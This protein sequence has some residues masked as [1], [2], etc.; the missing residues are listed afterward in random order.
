MTDEKPEYD[1]GYGRPPKHGRFAPG[2]SG[3]PK[4][5]KKGSK[6]LATD[7]AEELAEKIRVREGVR[8]RSVSKQRAILKALVAK[9]L[10]GDTRAAHLLI[11]LVAAQVATAPAVHGTKPPCPRATSSSSRT[12][13]VATPPRRRRRADRT[14]ARPTIRR[15]AMT[16]LYPGPPR[17]DLGGVSPT[18]L[19]KAMLP[20]D[21]P[22]F[23]AKAFDELMHE[24][25]ERSEY[26]ELLSRKLE[27]VISGEVRRLIVCL[28]PRV[29]KSHVARS[30][31]PPSCSART[32][33]RDPADLT[34]RGSGRGFCLQVYAA[35]GDRL[36]PGG[37]PRHRAGR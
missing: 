7:L 28:P 5:R 30:A 16:D 35:D 21:F 10:K 13:C 1:V 33:A 36:V 19:F 2:Q 15:P 3:N 14:R 37:F 22:T 17:V 11:G 29:L 23:V 9:A 25:L 20:R 31:C 34:Q 32:R 18:A 12:S 8:E 6:N 26:L 4:G 24:P 27:Q